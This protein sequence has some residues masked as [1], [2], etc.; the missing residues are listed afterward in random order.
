MNR[1]LF[2]MNSNKLKFLLRDDFT[3]TLAAGSVNG[4][5]ATP[6]PGTRQVVDT[7][8]K[9]SVGSGN[10]V[11]AGGKATPEYGDPG[12][13]LINPVT[14]LYGQ[15]LMYQ[16]LNTGVSGL[17]K[18]GFDANLVKNITTNTFLRQSNGTTLADSGGSARFVATAE[19]TWL[20]FVLRTAGIYAFIKGAVSTGGVWKLIYLEG[21]DT[22]TPLYVSSHIY[23]SNAPVSSI[24]V[25][26]SRFPIA[27]LAYDAFTRAALGS[28]EA[29]GPDSQAAPAL[30]WTNQVG[31][32]AISGNKAIATVV[33]VD[34]A[35]CTVPLG[36]ANHIV[37]AALVKGTTGAG[38]ILRYQDVDN[39]VYCWH[40]GTNLQLV[41]RVAGVETALVDTA[42][43][44]AAGRV[45]YAVSD[46][47]S[48]EAF[49][50]DIKIGAT[51]TIPA[52]TYTP[53]G[54]IFFDT[55][56]TLDIFTAYARGNEGQY[57]MLD[58][59]I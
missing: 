31:T 44:Y 36:T 10:L 43:T 23:S 32:V 48:G 41:K 24:R 8:N 18:Y 14:R 54:L 17:V 6:G 53:C 20:A 46:G 39:Y 22:T 49:Y 34:R 21:A 42:A 9:L 28:T 7:E 27:V 13:W 30:A 11:S 2:L 3:D 40:N 1:R 59:Y 12:F 15:I 19:T 35:I 5:L 47:T 4:T 33:P 45:I 56:S 26:L 50:Y 52:S 51:Q 16:I 37:S 29:T 55:D 58:K 57:S 38:I 25:P